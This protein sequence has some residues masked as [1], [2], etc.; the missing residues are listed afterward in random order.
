MRKLISAIVSIA[1]IALAIVP[2]AS[3][4]EGGGRKPSEAPLIAVG[5]HYTGQLTNRKDDANYGGDRQVAIWRLPPLSARDVIYVNWHSVPATNS[6]GYFPV[7][8]TFA[9]GIDD[10][11]WG[12]RF[13][14]ATGFE[15]EESAGPVYT[16]SGSGTARTAITVPENNADSSYLEF[17]TS[18]DETQP[19]R[20]ESFP[21]DFSIEPPL[22]YLGVAIREV[23]RVRANGLIRATATL[24]NGLP[25][26]DGL[27]FELAVTW[28]GGGSASYTGVSSGGVVSFQLA[29]PETAYG[30]RAIFVARHPADGSYIAA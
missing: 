3:A 24:A 28:D 5:E 17:Y 19:S 18:A 8:M 22:H 7:C 11:N 12:S 9:Q 6:P 4:L 29:L 27:S 14:A 1:L 2:S 20:F 10:Y 26:P 21:Y 23:K 15:C 13:D 16:L 25:A 30:E